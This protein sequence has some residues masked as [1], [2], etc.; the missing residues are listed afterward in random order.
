MTSLRRIAGIGLLVVLLPACWPTPGAGPD[1]R[2]HNPNE[3]TLT[4]A[5]VGELTQ[6]FR[7]PL[8]NGA[9]PPVVTSKGLFVRTGLSIGAFDSGSGSPRWL[10]SLPGEG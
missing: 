3:R 7:V 10:A 2:S 4:P 8:T 1:R 9:G 5:V 6:A